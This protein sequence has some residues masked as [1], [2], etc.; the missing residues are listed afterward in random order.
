MAPSRGHSAGAPQP[1]PRP[2][3]V[4]T[5]FLGA[6]KTTLLNRLLAS[7]MLERTA[8]IVNE[9]G[10]VGLDHALIETSSDGIIELSDGCVCC[11]VRGDLIDTIDRLLDGTR[12]IDR[13]VIETTGLADPVP[14]LRAIMAHP[15][16]ASMLR[17]DG[18]VTVVDAVSAVE[19]LDRHEEA[20]RQVAVADR[21]VVGKTDLADAPTLDAVRSA[22]ALLN[23]GAPVLVASE[24]DDLVREL[25]DCG[26][27]D[28][29]TK[30]AD[31]SR[32]LRDDAHRSDATGHAHHAGHSH[33]AGHAR[34]AG[35]AHDATRHG[36]SIRSFSLVHDGPVALGAVEDFLNLLASAQGP[37]LLRMKGIIHAAEHPDEPLVL[38]VVQTTMHP[39][40]RLP[41]WPDG[42]RRTRLVMI[43][44]GIAEG[45]VRDLFAAFTGQPR[46]DA[47]DRAALVENPLA[48]PGT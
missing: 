11:T 47:P 25:L 20:R 19:T 7:G 16:R 23:P 10:E 22:L 38:H 1:A 37:R 4:L 48:I 28:P 17:L 44:D 36:V 39:P 9:F 26:L 34:D 32:W 35:H 27:Y 14:V 3:T 21:L 45:W 29:A 46:V 13:I 31:V 8:V 41:A 30:R 15:T 24:L 43:V 33:Q 40:A 42:D 12:A 6:G 2:V 18:V 5:G